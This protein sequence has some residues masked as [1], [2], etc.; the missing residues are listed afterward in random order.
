MTPMSVSDK[1]AASTFAKLFCSGLGL[2]AIFIAPLVLGK[3]F[4][5]LW[6][7]ILSAINAAAYLILGL[8]MVMAPSTRAIWFVGFCLIIAFGFLEYNRL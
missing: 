2:I 4:G 6:G 1:R 7:V 5:P 8:R 3:I